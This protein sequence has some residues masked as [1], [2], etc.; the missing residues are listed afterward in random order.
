[1]ILTSGYIKNYG[2]TY[3]SPWITGEQMNRTATTLHRTFSRESIESSGQYDDGSPVTWNE[4]PVM[5]PGR[6]VDTTFIGNRGSSNGIVINDD[7][8]SGTVLITHSSGT[9]VQLDS[10][11]TILI[12]STGDTYNHS[13][14]TQFQMS[15]GD[16]HVNVGQNYNIM[17]EGGSNKI[18]VAGDMEVEC[19]NY[20]VTARGKM[21]FNSAEGIEMKG[22]TLSM[23]AHT[24]NIDIYS[25]KKLKVG[26]GTTM[27]LH[28]V[29]ALNIQSDTT[30]GAKSSEELVFNGSDVQIKGSTVYIDDIV[31]MAEGGAG[32]APDA[33]NPVVPEMT[34]PPSPVMTMGSNKANSNP[35]RPHPIAISGNLPDDQPV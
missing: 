33:E 13:E 4:P 7:D 5:S 28:S 22:A 25:A 20:L 3:L 27:S 21:T 30:L 17:I 12:K 14:G 8:A 26:S 31:R 32:D 18:W 19:E 29:E 24:D 34:D 6:S 11:G 1:M 15:T 16:T 2:N 9:V 35:I 23:E 10:Q